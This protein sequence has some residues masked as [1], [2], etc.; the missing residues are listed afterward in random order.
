MISNYKFGQI[1]VNN[2]NYG[3]DLTICRGKVFP[4]WW[5]EEGHLLQLSDIEDKLRV[6]PEILVV[7]TGCYGVMKIDDSLRNYCKN[8]EIILAEFP[9]GK[10]VDYFNNL[11]D[12]SKAVLA[13]HLTC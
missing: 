1:T 9:T 10:A 4:N 12:K 2:K 8:N 13:I 3:S 5:R 7:G 6:K 11:K